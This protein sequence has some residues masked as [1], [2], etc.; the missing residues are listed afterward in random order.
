[1]RIN[2]TCGAGSSAQFS[3]AR[4]TEK[5]NTSFPFV[6]DVIIGTTFDAGMRYQRVEKSVFHERGA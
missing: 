5:G 1:M 6:L 4:E 3:A 2:W